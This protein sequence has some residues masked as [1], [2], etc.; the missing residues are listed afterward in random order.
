MNIGNFTSEI[1]SK[2]GALQ[3]ALIKI[4]KQPSDVTRPLV[5]ELLR[6]GFR[7][8]TPTIGRLYTF[9][10]DAKYKDVL[11]YW[12]TQ[13]VILC[14]Q[15]HEGGDF[16]GLNFH[17]LPIDL[18]VQCLYLLDHQTRA[19][20][21]KILRVTWEKIK[22]SAARR[23]GEVT[24]KRYIRKNL[25]SRL[26]HIPAKN[27]YLALALPLANFKKATEHQVNSISKRYVGGGG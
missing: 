23:M 14:I 15:I 25:R 18:R 7:V 10:Y 4:G 2:A 21:A 9:T 16:T 19:N 13:P 11:P 20:D 8:A 5:E 6:G 22:A 3:N 12:D 1:I 26:V 27:W 17:Y 24:I